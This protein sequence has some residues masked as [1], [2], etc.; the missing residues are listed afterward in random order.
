MVLERYQFNNNVD[1]LN[2]CLQDS[3]R[4]SA[5]AQLGFVDEAENRFIRN[6]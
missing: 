4:K 5:L 3:I 1:S 6:L 2:F